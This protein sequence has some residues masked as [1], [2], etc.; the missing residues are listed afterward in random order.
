MDLAHR[1]VFGEIKQID[2][3]KF[4]LRKRV[5]FTPWLYRFYRV[6][7]V[8]GFEKRAE[9]PKNREPVPALS[10]LVIAS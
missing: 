9:N 5:K 6:Y 8:G 3:P 7:L 4:V 2:K 1:S 10:V